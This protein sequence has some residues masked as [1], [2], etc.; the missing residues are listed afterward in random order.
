MI[1]DGSSYPTLHNTVALNSEKYGVGCRTGSDWRSP[2]EFF[3]NF[4]CGRFVMK[5]C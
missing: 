3:T 2:H 1:G 4:L 5:C